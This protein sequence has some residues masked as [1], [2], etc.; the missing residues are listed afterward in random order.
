[1]HARPVVGIVTLLK[2]HYAPAHIPRAEHI[3]CMRKTSVFTISCFCSLHRN[4]RYQKLIIFKTCT[5]KNIFKVLCFSS[6]K[7]LLCKRSQKRIKS[8][9]FCWKRFCAK[10]CTHAEHVHLRS[11]SMKRTLNG[12]HTLNCAYEGVECGIWSILGTFRNTLGWTLPPANMW[13]PS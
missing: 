7:T 6:P 1:M 4:K 5:L 9:S 2:I 8:F 3:I 11:R 12:L 10:K 13:S